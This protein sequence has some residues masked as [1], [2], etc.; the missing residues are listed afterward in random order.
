MPALSNAKH[1]AFAVARFNG[2][3]LGGAVEK[4]GYKPHPSAGHRLLKNVKIAVRIAE[5]QADA[6]RKVTDSIAFDAVSIFTRLQKSI[7]AAEAAGAHTA[8]MTGHT[9]MVEAFG[10]RDSPTL[11]H[12]HVRGQR[13]NQGEGS[14]AEQDPQQPGAKVLRFGKLFKDLERQVR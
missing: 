7:D 5:L 10:Y 14:K 2:A 13:L 11:T 1:E 12:E 4:A 6:A 8:V 3:T 9:L